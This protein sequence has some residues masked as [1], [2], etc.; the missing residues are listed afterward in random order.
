LTFDPAPVLA[1][2]MMVAN[3]KDPWA[4]FDLLPPTRVQWEVGR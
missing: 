4:R 3:S 2:Y 1:T